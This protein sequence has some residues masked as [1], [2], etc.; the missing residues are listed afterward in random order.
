VLIQ[1]SEPD[2][3][4]QTLHEVVKMAVQETGVDAQIEKWGHS[5][6]HGL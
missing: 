2:V 1:C 5:E 6:D 4:S 3:R